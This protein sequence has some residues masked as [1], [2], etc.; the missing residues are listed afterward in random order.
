MSV[1]CQALAAQLTV[2]LILRSQSAALGAW[3]AMLWDE[4]PDCKQKPPTC[5]Q[6]QADSLS[7]IL[8]NGVQ[9]LLIG[10]LHVLPE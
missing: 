7:R 3:R 5:Q 4:C 8:Y 9:Q 2:Y 6:L 10:L 1:E